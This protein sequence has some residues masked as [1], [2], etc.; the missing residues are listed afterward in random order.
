MR[1]SRYVAANA[2]NGAKASVGVTIFDSVVKVRVAI[3]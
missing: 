2:L 1:L 3:K